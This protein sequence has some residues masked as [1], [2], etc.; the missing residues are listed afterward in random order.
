MN[1][2][3]D[4]TERIKKCQKDVQ[5]IKASQLLGESNY[6]VYTYQDTYET[7]L[8]SGQRPQFDAT[9][10]TDED[11]FA[12]LNFE[13]KFYVNGQ[14]ETFT[15]VSHLF[16]WMFRGAIFPY[17]EYEFDVSQWKDYV[18]IGKARCSFFE[19]SR[20]GEHPVDWNGKR[21][22]YELLVKSSKPGKLTVQW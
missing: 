22:R 14:R 8:S 9:F 18:N 3:M 4:L 7:T 12:I 21:V 20:Y 15:D 16:G 13:L 2:K 19:D 10:K 1:G 6:V 17:A 11:T 5:N